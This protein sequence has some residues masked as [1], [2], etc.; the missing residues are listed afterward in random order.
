MK[1]YDRSNLGS[2]RLDIELHPMYAE[3]GTS[4]KVWECKRLYLE[5]Q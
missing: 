1:G 5:C 3:A 2:N 4:Y